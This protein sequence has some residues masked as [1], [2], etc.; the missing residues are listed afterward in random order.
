MPLLKILPISSP[1]LFR[2]T[3]TTKLSPLL[4]FG[5]IVYFFFF[6]KKTQNHNSFLFSHAAIRFNT[7][8]V[9]EIL[10]CKNLKIAG[11]KVYVFPAY[12]EFL[13]DNP[14]LGEKELEPVDEPSNGTKVVI[15][16]YTSIFLVVTSVYC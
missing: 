15:Y 4:N 7:E 10:K 3:C 16:L 9:A 12:T 13:Q 8:R 6:R 11:K 14:K 2:I 5:K 1:M